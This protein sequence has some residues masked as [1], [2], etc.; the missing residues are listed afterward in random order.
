MF[1]ALAN[2]KQFAFKVIGGCAVFTTTDKDL[3]DDRLY[4]FDAVTE[5]VIVGW[6]IAPAQQGQAFLGNGLFDQRFA[7][8]AGSGWLRQKQHADTV[9]FRLWQGNTGFTANC[10]QESVGYLQQNAGTVAGFRVRANGTTVG[11]VFQDA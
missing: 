4:L 1:D 5:S 3:A 11:Q 8:T 6:Y 10:S 9:M 7:V 2:D